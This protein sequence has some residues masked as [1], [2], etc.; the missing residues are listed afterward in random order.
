MPDTKIVSIFLSW[1]SH[2]LCVTHTH[3]RGMCAAIVLNDTQLKPQRIT[4]SGDATNYNIH[5]QRQAK[6]EE[7]IK[8]KKM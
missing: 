4:K 1:N 7:K 2:R 5:R 3:T 6:M 8:W